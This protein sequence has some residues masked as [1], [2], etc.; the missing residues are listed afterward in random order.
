MS[1]RANLFN[2]YENEF[3]RFERVE[4]KRSERADLHGFLLLEEL[5]PSNRDMISA[6]EHDE[7][8]LDTGGEQL[9]EL[10]DEQV[11]ELLR[12]GIRYDPDYD[13]LAMFA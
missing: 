7:I 1:K 4:N 13:R 11:I 5:F 3:L 10:T 9:D 2:K 6:A 12:C 8:W